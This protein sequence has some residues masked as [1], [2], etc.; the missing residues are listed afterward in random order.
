MEKLERE[1]EQLAKQELQKPAT[2]AK[3]EAL[4]RSNQRH[5]GGYAKQKPEP[6]PQDKRGSR[7]RA[8]LKGS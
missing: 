5:F 6:K 1:V 7:Q 8:S 4:R 3:A 2:P